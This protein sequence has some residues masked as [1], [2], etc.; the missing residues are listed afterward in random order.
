MLTLVTACSSGPRVDRT[1]ELPRTADT[2]IYP[3]LERGNTAEGQNF[4]QWV[5]QT[6]RGL[7]SDAYVRDNNKLG[8]VISPQVKPRE[9]RSLASSLAQGF[10]NSFPGQDLTVLIYAPDKELIMTAEYDHQANVV[11]YN[12]A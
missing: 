9:V 1:G 7:V 8:V 4:G 2:A 5:V 10:H 11:T 6:A 12:A 3:A